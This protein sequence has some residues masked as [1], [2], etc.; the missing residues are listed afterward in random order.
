MCLSYFIV[1]THTI[2]SSLAEVLI[3]TLWTQET[4]PSYN[5]PWQE[6]RFIHQYSRPTWQILCYIKQVRNSE[7]INYFLLKINVAWIDLLKGKTM[8][9]KWTPAK[10]QVQSITL[11]LKYKTEKQLN[12]RKPVTVFIKSQKWPHHDEI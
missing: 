9:P 2:F 8:N 12:Q 5:N 6:Y 4:A 11:H 1:C 7:T 3:M 10:L